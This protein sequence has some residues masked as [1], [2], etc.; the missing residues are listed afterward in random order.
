MTTA[1][2]R[3]L[4]TTITDR[5]PMPALARRG[6]PPKAAAAPASSKKVKAKLEI[7]DWNDPIVKGAPRDEH[8]VFLDGLVPLAL[9]LQIKA[10]CDHHNATA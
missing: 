3:T 7:I 8:R 1:I 6:R 9:A 10:L 4:R 2:Y 5:Q